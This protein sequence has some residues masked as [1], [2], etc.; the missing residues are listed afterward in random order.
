MKDAERN[1]TPRQ[2]VVLDAAL[3]TVKGYFYAGGNGLKKSFLDKSKELESLKY[4]L[5]LYTQ[6]TDSLI[7]TFITSQ[8]EQGSLFLLLLRGFCEACSCCLDVPAQEEPVGEVS[9]Q[10][11]LFTHP[12]TGEHKC[13]VKSERFV[14]CE[15]F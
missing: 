14:L 10:V 6:T 2:C 12:G 11:E 8:K 15:L 7:K 13:T 1:L 9:I 4:A 5:S 3:D